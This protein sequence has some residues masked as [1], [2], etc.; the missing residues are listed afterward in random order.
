[1][2]G[3]APDAPGDGLDLKEEFEAT[4]SL[5]EPNMFLFRLPDPALSKT[6]T[7]QKS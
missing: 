2:S 3:I 1:M 6:K 7:G 5:A 4:I